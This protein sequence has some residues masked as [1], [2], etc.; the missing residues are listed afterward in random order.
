M[1]A[2]PTHSAPVQKK[3]RLS[4]PASDEPEMPAFASASQTTADGEDGWTKVEKRKAKKQKRAD[5]K[6]DV[7]VSVQV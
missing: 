5:E 6:S 4:P 3:Q 2:S 1:P 7:C